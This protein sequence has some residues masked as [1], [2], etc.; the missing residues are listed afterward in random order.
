MS[1]FAEC[2]ARAEREL[3]EQRDRAV[4]M[5]ARHSRDQEECSGL[6]SMLGLDAAGH[7]R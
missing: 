7:G 3:D 2:R 6:M 4:R 5:V 1:E